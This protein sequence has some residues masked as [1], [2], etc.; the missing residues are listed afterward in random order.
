MAAERKTLTMRI[1]P[2]QLLDSR[3]ADEGEAGSSKTSQD[4]PCL[5]DIPQS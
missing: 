1:L 2:P 3:E 5:S 4:R